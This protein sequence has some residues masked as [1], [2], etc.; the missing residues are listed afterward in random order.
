MKIIFAFFTL[1]ILFPNFAS[2]Q[3]NSPSSVI[4][5]K[6]SQKLGLPVDCTVNQDCWVMNYVDFDLSD[7]NYTDPNC[8]SRTYDTHKGTDF[9]ILDEKAMNNGVPVIAVKDGIIDRLR[10]GE[11]DTWKTTTDLDKIK[12]ERK[13]CGNAIMINHNDETKSIY[14]HLRQNSIIVEKGQNVKKGDIL[15]MVGMS[16]FTEFPHLHYGLVKNKEIIDPFTGRKSSSN[17]GLDNIKPLWDKGL[18]LSYQPFVIQSSGFSATIPTLD[19]LGRDAA[20]INQISLNDKNIVFW[21]I[22][23]G[24]RVDDVIQ[25]TIYDANNKIYTT[26][27]ITQDR[28][29]ARQLYYIGKKINDQNLTAGAYTAQ[30]KITRPSSDPQVKPNSNLQT[31]TILVTP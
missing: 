15:G 18:N 11:D 5:F 2:A 31:K 14:C 3:S 4:Q 21:A 23:L 26:Q 20:S 28:N 13:E 10:D 19:H 12:Q 25:L 7:N 27:E 30:V 16:G 9:A 22:L 24:V 17:C 29:R 6:K 8:Q 1:C